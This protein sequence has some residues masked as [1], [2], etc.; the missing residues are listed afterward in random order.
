MSIGLVSSIFREKRET[1]RLS[2][3]AEEPRI[4]E[5]NLPRVI[6]RLL[7]RRI[8]VPRAGVPCALTPQ[9][10]F[11]RA[12]TP[13]TLSITL[14]PSCAPS[15]TIASL[16]T[17]SC[18]LRRPTPLP[19]KKLA[20]S[21]SNLGIPQGARSPS[22]KRQ[23][24]PLKNV[25]P[26]LI[27]FGERRE[28]QLRSA[29]GGKEGAHVPRYQS[30][31]RYCHSPAGTPSSAFASF[32]VPS[33]YY[34]LQDARSDAR[35]YVQLQSQFF[36]RSCSPIDSAPS[37]RARSPSPLDRW[38]STG[39][40]SDYL[41]PRSAYYSTT[42]FAT[43]YDSC[44]DPSFNPDYHRDRYY[45]Q[46]HP[47]NCPKDFPP[48]TARPST[49]I[50]T[51]SVPSAYKLAADARFPQRQPS[52]CSSRS[53]TPLNSVAFTP[54]QRVQSFV[55][56]NR[57][58]STGAPQYQQFPSTGAPQY[59]RLPDQRNPLQ[60]L[61]L[62]VLIATNARHSSPMSV[63]TRICS[64]FNKTLATGSLVLRGR[65]IPRSLITWRQVP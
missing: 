30:P 15:R 32:A 39:A 52:R 50:A 35:F 27:D 45:Q 24:K 62:H 47:S 14:T 4:R 1:S 43:R 9:T 3:L 56:I 16:L 37:Q 25:K 46:L 20:R 44:E 65:L 19:K 8:Q 6:P 51:A 10:V 53:H 21:T 42:N 23:I 22:R 55:P 58:R 63:A 26:T 36:S 7:P 61:L 12:S 33:D 38:P 40:T 54:P 59:Q 41:V 11:G 49:G 17:T 29:R 28:W 34:S 18:R 31:Q 13:C 2:S 64:N 60:Q 5:F 57:G 48:Q